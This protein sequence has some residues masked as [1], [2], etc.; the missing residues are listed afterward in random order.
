[1]FDEMKN[2]RK[3]LGQA[4]KELRN[5]ANLPQVRKSLRLG[6]AVSDVVQPFMENKTAWNAGVAAWKIGQL[7]INDMEVYPDDFYT[8]EWT[9]LYASDFVQIV[10]CTLDGRDRSIIRT[11]EENVVICVVAIDDVIFAYTAKADLTPI[12]A[13]YART[14]QVDRA[15]SYVKEE[16]WRRLKHDNIVLRKTPPGSFRQNGGSPISLDPDDAFRPMTS[17]RSQSYSRYLQRCISAGVSRSVMFFGPPGTGKS[18]LARTIVS[19]LGM[20]SFRIRVEDVDDIDSSS[21]FET[22]DIFEPDAIIL[23]DFDRATGQN[24]LLE[25]LEFFQRHV[26]L[27]LATVNDK[28]RLDPAI[29]R[30]GRF[31]ELVSVDKMDED[32]VKVVLG[33]ENV[34]AMDVVKNWPIAYI[35]E[36]VKRKRFM[37]PEEARLSTLELAKRVAEMRGIYGSD[38]SPVLDVRNDDA[39]DQPEMSHRFKSAIEKLAIPKKKKGRRRPRRAKSRGLDVE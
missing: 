7:I 1:V 31:D 36:Y 6:A 21:I 39:S 22:I 3:A 30:P 8:E 20:R 5:I 17:E 27:V 29:L 9:Q 18:T 15:R 23:D 38:D 12:S 11:S 4:L 26:K 34:D 19:D 2:L 33:E 10:I 13:L 16:M 32:V 24:S 37:D 25:T 14:D 28:D 35:H